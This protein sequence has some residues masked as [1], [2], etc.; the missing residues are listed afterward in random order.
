MSSFFRNSKKD[1]FDDFSISFKP[2]L[3]TV[4]VIYND[5]Y[6]KEYHGIEEPWKYMKKVKQNPDVKST[7]IK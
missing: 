6:K 7:Y 5:G 4:V 3:Y 2:K 1:F